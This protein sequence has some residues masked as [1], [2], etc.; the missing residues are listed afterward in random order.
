MN[1]DAAQQE[2]HLRVMFVSLDILPQPLVSLNQSPPLPPPCGPWFWP[3]D[4]SLTLRRLRAAA[5]LI[6]SSGFS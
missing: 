5:A 4:S 6:D 2:C 3:R 1:T